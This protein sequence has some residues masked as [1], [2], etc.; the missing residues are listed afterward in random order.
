MYIKHLSAYLLTEVTYPS[1]AQLLTKI[2]LWQ[3]QLNF[4]PD[5]T[6]ILIYQKE[7]FLIRISFFPDT[8]Y[9]PTSIAK[10]PRI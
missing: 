3:N 4:S 9:T 8:K 1:L 2:L 5:V 10:A 6:S 7:T